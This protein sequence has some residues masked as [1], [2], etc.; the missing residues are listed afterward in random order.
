MD[1]WLDNLGH[2][3]GGLLDSFS[4]P[5]DGD[6]DIPRARIAFLDTKSGS[7]VVGYGL[8]HLSEIQ[9]I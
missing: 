9:M 2:D 4:L 5:S 8:D 1:V 7:S 6:D 3:E